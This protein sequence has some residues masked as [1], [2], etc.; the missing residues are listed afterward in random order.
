MTAR[1]GLSTAVL[2]VDFS[3]FL[4]FSAFNE[5]LWSPSV[6]C[7]PT[8]G[9]ERDPPVWGQVLFGREVSK[10]GMVGLKTVPPCENSCFWPQHHLWFRF[11]LPKAAN[12][13][14]ASNECSDCAGSMIVIR[15]CP[16][17]EFLHTK[18]LKVVNLSLR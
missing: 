14:L 3:A 17:A 15:W 4:C 13:L 18:D 10:Q 1:V 7:F 9:W 5:P 8:E 12:F 2:V 16:S 11:F 6:E